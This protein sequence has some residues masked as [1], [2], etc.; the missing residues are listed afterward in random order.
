MQSLSG[1]S[2]SVMKRQCPVLL[3]LYE[4]EYRQSKEAP[5]PACYANRSLGASLS[6]DSRVGLILEAG[7]LLADEK[8]YHRRHLRDNGVRQTAPPARRLPTRYRCPPPPP[9]FPSVTHGLQSFEA[10]VGWTKP[11]GH[12]CR[13]ASAPN[14][15]GRR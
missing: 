9:P 15:P 8:V 10:Q 12:I 4:H 1:G 11:R 14:L 2:P 7:L 6:R 13:R 5:W 3:S